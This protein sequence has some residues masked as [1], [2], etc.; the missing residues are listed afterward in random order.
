MCEILGGRV[1]M[2]FSEIEAERSRRLALLAK[3]MGSKVTVSSRQQ[4]VPKSVRQAAV[5]ASV[6]AR[7]VGRQHVSVISNKMGNTCRSCFTLWTG[8]VEFKVLLRSVVNLVVTSGE[9]VGMICCVSKDLWTWVEVL[10][11]NWATWMC[12]NLSASCHR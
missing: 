4:V 10:S 6:T 5:H 1:S 11:V 12:V 7:L 2:D 8:C 9:Y 3:L